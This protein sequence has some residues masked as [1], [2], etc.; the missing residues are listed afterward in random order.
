MYQKIGL[1][2]ATS[3]SPNFNFPKR[4][5]NRI[6]FIIIHY[7]GMKK[8]SAAIK[9]LQDPKSKVSSHYLIKNNGGI[10]N[11]VPDVYEAW[12]AGVSSWRHFTSLN[13]NSIGIEITNP[14]HQYGYRNFSSKQILS[15][16]KLLYFLIKKYRI[17]KNC[18]LGHSDISP[19][20]KKDPGEKFPWEMLA[21]KKLVFWH[22]LN[23]KKI[24]KFRHD[25][26]LTNI[27]EKVFLKNL[28]KIGYNDVKG[29]KFRKNMK[30]LTL[31]FQRRFRQSLVNGKVDK[32]CLLISKNLV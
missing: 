12:H 11:L 14:G 9:R 16:K 5:K 22:N 20:R 26:L 17:K 8:E 23:Q 6:K 25:N 21:K 27:E 7:T 30:Y 15:L 24:K 28:H 32:E 29:F 19:R 2:M 3:Y 31:A 10:I 13:Q 1:K 18:V 4:V